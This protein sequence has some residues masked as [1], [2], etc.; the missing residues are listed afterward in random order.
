MIKTVLFLTILLTSETDKLLTLTSME[1]KSWSLSSI[2]PINPSNCPT[3]SR[4]FEDNSYTF[5]VDGIFEFDHGSITQDPNCNSDDCCGDMP[6]LIGK[7]EFLNNETQLRVTALRP[8]D[9]TGDEFEPIVLFYG[10][11][12]QLDEDVLKISQVNLKNNV[13]Y[14]YEFRKR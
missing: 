13:R 10:R 8:K 6:N 9:V 12:D 5:F 1:R 14:T 4:S 2:T 11:I 3:A 7:W